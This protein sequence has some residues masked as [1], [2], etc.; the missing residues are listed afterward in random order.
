MDSKMFNF[1]AIQGKGKV[2]CTLVQALRLYTGRTAH[3]SSGIA[4]LFIDHGTR[5]EWGVSS[6]PRPLFT[7]GKDPVPIV[8]EARWAPGP[9]W[10]RTENLVR[11]GIRS[12]DRP[13]R[14]QSLY[15]AHPFRVH[16]LNCTRILY[17]YQKYIGINMWIRG[18][19][20]GDK[21]HNQLKKEGNKNKETRIEKK[22]KTL[23]LVCIVW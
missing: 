7:P 12:P 22:T 1:L 17:I 5:M 21:R 9:V 23:A 11:T 6:T 2:Q 13:A 20:K 15:P 19:G 8:H 14:N 3:R 18:E 16:R 4:L 10:T